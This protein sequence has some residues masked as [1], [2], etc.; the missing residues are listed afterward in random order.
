MESRRI[1]RGGVERSQVRVGIALGVGLLL[2][3]YGVVRVGQLFDVFAD[4]YPLVTLAPTAAGLLEG[5]PVTLAGQRVGQVERIDFI[6]IERQTGEEHIRIT[7]SI[8]RDVR[9]Q[10]RGDSKAQIQ[11]RGLLGDK[12]VDVQPGSPRYPMLQPGDTLPSEPVVDLATVLDNANRTLVGAQ[13]TIRNLDRIT[14][15]LVRGE[16]TLGRLLKDEALYAQ[17]IYTTRSLAVT[18][19]A[20]HT[21]DGTLAR[22]IHDPTLYQELHRAVARV[23]SLG[24]SI[25]HGTGTLGQLVQNDS[26]YQSVLGTVV[27]ADSAVAGIARMLG[28]SGD[29]QGTLQKVLTDPALYDQ[30][31]KAIVDL[32]TLVADIRA[33]P[34]RYRP[35]VNIEVF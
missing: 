30:F 15:G 4:R 9:A 33:H 3:A 18:L 35:E 12:F 29:E 27:R 25:L 31:L 21:A 32:Q 20:I 10:I 1:R 5:A 13:V 14:A 23:D 26:L 6:P 11:T 16:G 34:L 19:R 28:Q 22:L 17:M 2:L 7:L 8:N 24:A